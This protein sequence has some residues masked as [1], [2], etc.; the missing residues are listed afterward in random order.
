LDTTSHL[1]PHS[2]MRARGQLTLPAPIREA[3]HLTEGDE[4]IFLQDDDGVRLIPAR[5]IPADQAWFWT[6]AWQAG[7]HEASCDI[8]AGYTSGPMSVEEFTE[9]LAVD[10]ADV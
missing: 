2:T 9:S 6:P 8:A 3:L 1:T 7:E 10:A 5:V 4:V